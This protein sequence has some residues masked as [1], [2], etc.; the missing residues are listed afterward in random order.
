MVRVIVVGEQHAQLDPN[1]YP[2]PYPNGHVGASPNVLLEAA[3]RSLLASLTAVP[4]SSEEAT[5][6]LALATL[7]LATLTLTLT[8]T[9]PLTPS[10][11]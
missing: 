2:N 3:R 6:T 1:P 8:L 10:Q 7:A 9:S 11:P 5:L 4:L